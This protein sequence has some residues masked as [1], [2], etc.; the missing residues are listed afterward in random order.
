M[1][2]IYLFPGPVHTGKT[3]RLTEWIN[4]KNDVDGILQPLI[5]G[6]RHIKHILSGE[7][8][9]LEVIQDF[10]QQNIISIGDYKFSADV[11]EWAQSQLLISFNRNPEWIII[12]EVGKLEMDNKGLEPAVSEII[13]N[14]NKDIDINLVFVVRDYL[15]PNFLK[16][17]SLTKNDI[18]VLKI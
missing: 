16:K 14:L 2:Q 4:N 9:L 1:S 10:D 7:T 12:D 18:R 17:Y 15:I 8:R 11:F 5:N 13:N 6:R 3:T